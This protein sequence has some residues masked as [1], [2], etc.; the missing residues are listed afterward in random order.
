MR[1]PHTSPRALTRPVADPVS[2]TSGDD[3]GQR[4]AR[5]AGDIATL[6][7]RCPWTAALT[8]QSLLEYLI[9]ES[10]EVVEAVEAGHTGAEHAQELAGELGDVLFQVLLHAR[11][12]EEAGHFGIGDVVESLT[13]K[14]IRRNPHVFAPDGT[15][16]STTTDDPADIERAWDS[17]KQQEKPE[18][19]SPF[20]GIPAG[21][22]AL[23]LAAKV[24]DRARRAG[25]P[26][27]PGEP[28][29]P[30]PAPWNGE[31]EL[32]DHLFDVVLRAQAQGLDAE[33]ALRAAVGRF[34]N[35]S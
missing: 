8:H 29:G 17:I 35:R 11:L 3:L 6:R 23:L 4:F 13:A 15:L 7:E 32:G 14:M 22:P 19:T 24:Q 25:V 28:D 33:A 31:A 26:V 34:T 12:Q 10:Y 27:L 1:W 9:E 20:D 2:G 5:L 16:R 18:R 21:L 30:H